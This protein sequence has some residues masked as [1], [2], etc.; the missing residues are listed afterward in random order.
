[1]MIGQSYHKT[2][3]ISSPPRAIPTVI[4]GNQKKRKKKEKKERA[5]EKSSTLTEKSSVHSF[6][7]TH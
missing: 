3:T 6:S 2:I 1:M 7:D 4:V 5:I